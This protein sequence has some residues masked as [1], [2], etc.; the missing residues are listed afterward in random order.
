MQIIYSLLALLDSLASKSSV[1][2]IVGRT[3]ARQIA[4]MFAQILRLFQTILF[5]SPNPSHQKQVFLLDRR[6]LVMLANC[7]TIGTSS[8]NTYNPLYG[9]G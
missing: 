9:K 4:L 2:S 8:A 6:F 3:A 1:P 5:L 7:L